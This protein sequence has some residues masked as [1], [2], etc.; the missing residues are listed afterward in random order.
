MRFFSFQIIFQL[1]IL[2]FWNDILKCTNAFKKSAKYQLEY[3]RIDPDPIPDFPDPLL[4][5]EA[6]NSK[7]GPAPV[8]YNSS[9]N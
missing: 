7:F 4:T 3:D 2:L 6:E 5:S 8:K 1:R 9:F